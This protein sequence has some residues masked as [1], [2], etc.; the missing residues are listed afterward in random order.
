MFT[1]I[2]LA[3]ALV[4]I[5]AV[6]ASIGTAIGGITNSIRNIIG[7]YTISGV[8]ALIIAALL[9]VIQAYFA[10]NITDKNQRT[11]VQALIVALAIFVSFWNPILKSQYLWTLPWAA[12]IL[13]IKVIINL[14]LIGIFVYIVASFFKLQDKVGGADKG[15]VV[16]ILIA[17]MI[18]A[19]VALQPFE[20]GK[21]YNDATYKFVWEYESVIDA[22]LFLL[23]DS[24]CIYNEK[25]GNKI[26]PS[27]YCYTNESKSALMA[28]TESKQV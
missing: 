16:L 4:S 10:K 23:G 17:I 3:I 6:N 2:F 15:K 13:H 19:S 12:N 11:I 8:N 5:T 24:N 22:R 1:L 20:G 26:I 28:G 18:S 7:K 21:K 14:V 25:I 9:F 27:K